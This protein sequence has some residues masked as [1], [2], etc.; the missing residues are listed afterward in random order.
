MP[1]FPALPREVAIGIVLVLCQ[2]IYSQIY[3]ICLRIGG[4]L[5]ESAEV[6]DQYTA[7][8]FVPVNLATVPAP[9]PSP[10][11]KTAPE[12][13]PEQTEVPKRAQAKQA[14]EEDDESLFFAA[15]KDV[16]RRP[17]GKQE[18]APKFFLGD[19]VR[20][21]ILFA[22]GV[23][24]GWDAHCKAPEWWRRSRLA[25][26][27]WLRM[28]HYLIIA[29]LRDVVNTNFSVN[30]TFYAPEG[31]LERLKDGVSPMINPSLPDYFLLF[32]TSAE[33]YIPKEALAKLYPDDVPRHYRQ[34]LPDKDPQGKPLL[35][36]IELGRLIAHGSPVPVVRQG[37]FLVASETFTGDFFQRTVILLL[38]HDD[39]AGTLGVIVNRNYS[40]APE[41]QRLL[42]AASDKVALLEKQ[43]EE[44]RMNR[45]S[46]DKEA[47][48]MLKNL[49]PI[50]RTGECLLKL[51]RTRGV[52]LRTGGPVGLE[53]F[54]FGRHHIVIH[55][56]HDIKGRMPALLGSGSAIDPDLYFNM[57]GDMRNEDLL[58]VSRRVKDME[59]GKVIVFQGNSGW[60]PK[61]LAGEIRGS[62]LGG[63][64]WSWI[65][66]SS[67]EV[68]DLPTDEYPSERTSKKG[69]RARRKRKEGTGKG[70]GEAFWKRLVAAEA[71]Q[72]LKA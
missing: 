59:Y 20:D 25:F 5:P 3:P 41:R 64:S 49:S 37:M 21:R 23:I 40:S 61:Q 46:A 67:E 62:L 18:P 68:L 69:K 51:A 17:R 57:V 24:V 33:R 34:G 71:L 27:E 50:V 26:P 52:E 16:R 48:E 72:S 9:T 36:V 60:G 65:S 66:A 58:E 6:G 12:A 38:R 53:E 7:T 32:D 22:R 39:E 8:P 47:R 31:T 45:A 35:R 19:T 11:S 43:V 15:S 10:A 63:S 56:F 42:K 2:L 29:D 70:V 30:L 28:P 54:P 44:L 4:F 55:P 13:V 1:N 14:A